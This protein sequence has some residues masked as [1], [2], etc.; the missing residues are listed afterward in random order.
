MRKV[1]QFASLLLLLAITVPQVRAADPIIAKYGSIAGLIFKTT[2]NGN[3]VPNGI[4]SRNKYDI[5]YTCAHTNAFSEGSHKYA[6][7][8]AYSLA[9]PP[10][11]AVSADS[12]A[13]P[14]KSIT[15]KSKMFLGPI[16]H[17]AVSEGT[18]TI[19]ITYKNQLTLT[20]LDGSK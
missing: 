1:T 14:T 4:H 20:K 9:P 10:P 6:P 17:S 11:A 19:L 7:I 8:Y 15:F 16:G 3:C 12:P 5:L 18:N 13:T 2:D